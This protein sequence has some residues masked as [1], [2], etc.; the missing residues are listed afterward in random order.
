MVNS[1]L[2]KLGTAILL[3]ASQATGT[4]VPLQ[5]QDCFATETPAQ[6]CYTAKNGATPQDVDLAD[7]SFVASYLRSYGRQTRL[8]RLFTMN[9]VDTQNCAEWTLYTHGSVM[10]TAKH[11]DPSLNSSVLFEDIANTIDGG[12]KATDAQKAKALLGCGTDGG[13]VGVIVNS[14]A[15]AYHTTAYTT[16][17]FSTSGLIVKI[18]WSGAS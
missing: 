8:G 6:F 14:T 10:A 12:E 5:T 9:S 16:G 11:I 15:A 4:V 13:A 7:I 2:L 3:A 18:V 1:S 17:N